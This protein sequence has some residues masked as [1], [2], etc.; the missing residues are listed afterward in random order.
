MQPPTI[1]YLSNIHFD[2]GAVDLLPALLAQL[3]IDRP[4][5]VTDEGLVATGL[6]DQLPIDAPVVF[7][8]VLPNPTESNVI[9]GVDHFR[10]NDCDGIIAFGGGSPID[11][12]KAIA[13]LIRHDPPLEQYA[14]IRG[15]LT[16]I[17][18]DQPPLIAIPTTAGTGS[19]VG[20]AAL[21]TFDSGVKLGML[22]PHL[23]PNAVICDPQLTL[24]LPPVLTAATGMDAI[25]HCVETYLSPKYNPVAEAIALDGLQRACAH[26]R[27][28]AADGTNIDH[29]REMMMAALQG[30]M[31]F[32]K[33]L[34]AIHSLSHPLGALTDKRLHH[35]MLNAIFLPHVLRFNHDSCADK[36]VRIAAALDVDRTEDISHL[37]SDINRQLGLPQRLG[38]LGVVQAD[39]EPLAQQAFS[40]HCSATNPRSVS[41]E[42]CA[43]L[44]AQAL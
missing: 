1:A 30:G 3:G 25:S 4:M 10:A 24:G 16:K 9:A 13:V 2:Q 31:T 35:G 37:F 27:E 39:L 20:R 14:F 11:C 18:A 7:D 15:G 26:I 12:A 8:Q 36:M 41:V 40:D 32:Q 21:I 42:D 23:I 29:R 38:E 19:E 28:V 17:T 43:R 34:G 44:Y 6:V 5:V 33:G 22:S